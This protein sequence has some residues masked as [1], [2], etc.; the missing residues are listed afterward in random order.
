[1]A[2]SVGQLA[3][4][5]LPDAYFEQ[6][7]PKVNAVT[8][9]DVTRVAQTYLDPGRAIVLVVGDHKATEESLARLSFAE[10]HVLPPAG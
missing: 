4:F 9:A 7:V 5:D 2:R 8:I 6:F 3:L 10:M 1:M